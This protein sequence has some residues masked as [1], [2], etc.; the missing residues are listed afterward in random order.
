M[1]YTRVVAEDMMRN[2][3]ILGTKKVEAIGCPK[4]MDVGCERNREVKDNSSTLNNWKDGA[5][6]SWEE[7]VS[8][9]DSGWANL[10]VG[11]LEL[12]FGHVETKWRYQSRNVK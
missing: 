6:I 12:S 2:G 10:G 9:G 1:V 11:G 5:A 8:L 7:K 3:L 4:G